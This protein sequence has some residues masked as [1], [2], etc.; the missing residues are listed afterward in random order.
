[1]ETVQ[2]QYRAQDVIISYF[3]ANPLPGQKYALL[4]SDLRWLDSSVGGKVNW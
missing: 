2:P 4:P 1:M 3:S